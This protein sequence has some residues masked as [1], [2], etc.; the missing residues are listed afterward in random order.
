MKIFINVTNVEE[1]KKVNEIE[2]NF[3]IDVNSSLIL[4]NDNEKEF[5]EII[6]V[7][8]VPVNI[9]IKATKWR[10]IVEEA[11]KIASIYKNIII[12]IPMSVNGLKACKV[13]K[14]QGIKTNIISISNSAQ[15]LLAA[16][17]GADYISVNLEK[18]E[19]RSTKKIEIIKDISNMYEYNNIKTKIICPE[20]RTLLNIIESSLAKANIVS[21]PYNM[22]NAIIRKPLIDIKIENT[23]IS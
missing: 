10:D 22:V 1:I 8:N 4:E 20:C 16:E 2:K 6:N 21:V 5:S 15:A 11:R 3:G 14:I 9:E 12:K 19:G 17:A 23:K 13:L 7:M 18:F